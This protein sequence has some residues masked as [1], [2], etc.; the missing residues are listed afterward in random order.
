[1]ILVG[2]IIILLVAIIISLY[3][4]E[5]ERRNIY[6][7]KALNFLKKFGKKFIFKLIDYLYK[8]NDFFIFGILLSFLLL[9]SVLIR[10]IF[11]IVYHLLKFIKYA[12]MRIT[13]G[14]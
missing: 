9:L 10:N 13:A 5:E 8:Y 2:I 11:S 1:M 7:D 4:I 14:R 3:E 12:I 6:F